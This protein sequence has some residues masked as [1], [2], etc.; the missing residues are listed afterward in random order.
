MQT[1]KKRDAIILEEMFDQEL[2]KHVF[3]VG[4]F[5]QI[6]PKDGKEDEIYTAI[7][8]K[9]PPNAKIYRKS[10]LPARFKYGKHPRIA[11]LLVLPDPG[12]IIMKRKDYDK[13][14]KDGNLD[15]NFG[16]HGYDNQ[17]ESMRATFIAH[18]SAFKKGVVVEPFENIQI[19]N[20][21]A[22]ILGLTPA[23][24]DGDFNLVKGFLK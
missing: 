17:L 11:P 13:A 1:Y 3:Y 15:K 20:L 10:E 5:T 8:S 2:A 9:L 18:G 7:K 16:A 23:K 6:F 19:Y 21:M 12:S 22:K 14:K 24:N 4:E